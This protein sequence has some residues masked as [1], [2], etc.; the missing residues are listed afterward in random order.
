MLIQQVCS[1]CWIRAFLWNVI[2]NEKSLSKTNKTFQQFFSFNG[3]NVVFLM[4]S[5]VCTNLWSNTYNKAMSAPIQ[6]EGWRWNQVASL[7]VKLTT[8]KSTYTGISLSQI[9][10]WAKTQNIEKLRSSIYWKRHF[11]PN[12]MTCCVPLNNTGDDIQRT[13]WPIL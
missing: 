13:R 4:C 3:W 11:S 8:I 9:T 1:I 12:F 7:I 2:E 6:R 10:M 5:L